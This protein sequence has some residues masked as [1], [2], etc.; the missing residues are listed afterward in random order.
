MRDM[1]QALRVMGAG[2]ACGRW[3]AR[4]CGCGNVRRGRRVRLG[5]WVGVILS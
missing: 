3:M 1:M 4:V 2:E 5:A